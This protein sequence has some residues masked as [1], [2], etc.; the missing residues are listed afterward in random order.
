MQFIPMM[1]K[2]NF[3]SYQSFRNHSHILIWCSLN[4]SY[5]YKCNLKTVV[6]ID[7]FVETEMH[8]VQDFWWIDSLKEQHLF[9]IEIFYNTKDTVICLL[10]VYSFHNQL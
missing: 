10:Y 2:L 3:N 1:A 8:F 4:I 7:I 6:L 5:Y 9:E